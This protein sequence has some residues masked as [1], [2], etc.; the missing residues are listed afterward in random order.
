MKRMLLVLAL[1]GC[2]DNTQPAADAG[3][4]AADGNPGSD[5]APAQCPSSAG[6]DPLEAA[7]TSCMFAAGAH[8]ADTLGLGETERARIPIRHIVVMMKENRSFDHLFGG[9]RAMQP[10]AEVFPD[11]FTNPDKTGA[12]VAPFHLATTC[13][14]HDPDHQWAAMHAQIDGGRMDGYIT[15]AA[16]TT[17]SDGHFALGYYEASDLPFYYFLASTY[18]VADHYFPSV[19]SGTFPNRDYMLLGTSDAV[20]ATQFSVWP[21]P[22]LP[23]IFDRLDAAGISWGVYGDDHALEETLNNPAHNWEHMHPWHPVHELMAAF[24]NDTLPNV[25]FVDGTENIQDE[26]PTADVQVGE[27]WTK[28]IYDAA[29]ASPAWSSTVLLLTYDEAGGFF[30]H[31]PPPNTCLARPADHDFFELGTRVPLIAI[32]PWA[33]RHYVSKPVRQHTSI[34]RFIEAV[35]GLPA[36]TARDANSDGLLDM[37]DFDCPPAAIPA[38]PA[39]GTG[40]CHGANLS[41]SKTSYT[42]GET[43]VVTFSGGP[44]NARDWIGV[45]PAGTT[46]HPGSTIWEYVGGS[47]TAGAALTQGTVQLG[48]GS[49]TWPLTVGSWTAYFLV[50]DGY[51]PIGSIEFDVR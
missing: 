38:A 30:D 4:P 21:D 23:T 10:D 22:S 40:G 26:H 46:P 13:V 18:A 31:V 29:V 19:R 2:G 6:A 33:R 14:G 37:F 43:I 45:Y 44:G 7:R 16:N 49:G 15:S 28:S 8:A 47:H 48:A 34:T 25:V 36:L 12:A 5:A 11:G 42:A 24:A 1:V 9:L 51:T 39:A 41:T 32:S 35:F 3:S 50:D 20:R 17:G 27:A